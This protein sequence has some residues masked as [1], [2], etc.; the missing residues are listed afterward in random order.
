MRIYLDYAA[1]TPLDPRVLN[2]MKPYFYKKFGNSMSLHS[3]GLEAKQALEESREAVAKFMNANAEEVIFTGSATE[4]INSVIKGI[5]FANKEKGKHIITSAIEHHAVLESCKW[6]E[7]Q[8]FEIT[9][10]PV[11]KY[12]LVDLE[13]LRASI[14]NDTILVSI[15]HANNEIGT[16]EPIEEIG[17]ICKERGV[18]FHTDAVQSFGKIPIDVNKMNIDLLSLSAHKFYGPKGVGA[19]FI[20]KGT[21]IDPLLHGGGHEFG[22]RSSTENIAGAVGLAEA[23]RLREKEMKPEAAR[24][25]KLRDY[26][27][28]NVLKIKNSYLNGHPTKRLSNNANFWFAFIEGEALIM[29]LDSYGIA[30]STGSACSSKTLEPSHVLKAIGLKHEEAHGSLRLSLGKYTTKTEIDYTIKILPKVIEN[31]RKLSPFKGKWK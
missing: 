31:L 30:A 10:L 8:G 27:I 16:I 5:A 23:I 2:A 21:N 1:T 14:R 26:L 24:L 17:K 20:R 12:G 29:Q 13:K 11:D 6:L 7:E 4:S 25:T 28:R 22:L 15:M 18:L 19:T 3:F 9:Y